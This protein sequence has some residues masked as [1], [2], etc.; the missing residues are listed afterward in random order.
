[1]QRASATPK[2]GDIQGLRAV[3]V[4]A[5]VVYHYFPAVIPGGFVGVDVFFVISGFLI[6]L[7]LIKEIDLTG[8]ISMRSFYA[9]RLRRL[10]PASLT[11]TAATVG[12]AL[13][14]FGP[15]QK[16]N[17]LED[18]AWSTAYL[19]NFHLAQSPDGYFAN[20]DP[21]LFMHFWSLAVEEQY[22]LVWP[23]VL[24]VVAL[25]A[26][27]RWRLVAPVVLASA[28]VVSLGAS[29]ALTASGSN[30][31]YYSLGTRAWELA[32]GGAVAFLVFLVKRQPSA[33]V[34]SVAAAIGIV[35]IFSSALI[36]SDLTPFPSWTA[37]VPTVGTA[38]VIWAGSYHHEGIASGLGV[39]PL[40]FIGDISYS[41]YLWHW[42]VLT[43]GV[44]IVGFSNPAKLALL[45]VSALLSVAT[46]YG[47]E[48][49]GARLGISLPPARVV[50]IGIASTLTVVLSLIAATASFPT[51]GGPA[52]AVGGP[53]RVS[54]AVHESTIVFDKPV[55]IVSPG[56]LPQNVEPT[57]EAL[58]ADLADVFLGCMGITA[59][60]CVGGDPNGDT[61]VVL[62]GDSQAGHWWP[63]GDQAARENGWKLFGVAKSG[64]PLAEVPV[65]ATQE[66]VESPGCS[67]WRSEAVA[68]I[69][70]IDPDLILFANRGYGYGVEDP[71]N[72]SDS[73][74]S[75][76][77]VG[78][79]PIARSLASIAPLVYFG[80]FP[81]SADDIGDCLY[82]NLK[83][84]DNCATPI[85][86]ALP[87]ADRE[88]DI[89][90]AAS[91]DAVYFDPSTLVC[92]DVCPV[93]DR[94]RI[95]YRDSG[96][97]NA[98][99]SQRLSPAF[100]A[101]VASTLPPAYP[102]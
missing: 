30:D 29:V 94:N 78:V 91:V 66:E 63:A 72:M 85:D 9:R 18:A 47:I 27:R 16:A 46:Y 45:A 31:A 39:P 89:A 86:I 28:L 81:E 1:M 73:E 57:L 70:A 51:T 8:R 58:P 90:T 14:L 3:A 50:V 37:A 44:A 79:S 33:V 76:W 21:S 74:I 35:A 36:F 82:R 77:E 5:V 22:Y 100:A 52:V 71:L 54:A 15:L 92:T 67:V 26:K 32:I 60:T 13:V 68:R 11:V 95:I 24:L 93:V 42:P 7:L 59:A 34:T 69:E 97:F 6:T 17:V 55:D 87:P 53:V 41:L 10:L 48:R 4:V 38:L 83:S 19:A 56:W 61:T 65:T 80:R 98:S 49:R 62:A 25:L 96:H 23:A 102:R 84:V 99:Y 40:R 12:A 20:S 2:R 75:E 101:I 43:F 88:R 64:C